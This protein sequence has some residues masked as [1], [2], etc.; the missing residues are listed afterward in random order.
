[1]KRNIIIFDLFG[2]VIDELEHDWKLGL[3]YLMDSVLLPSDENA[4]IEIAKEFQN[5]NMKNR[6]TTFIE[7]KMLDQLALFKDRIGFKENICKLEVEFEFLMASREC[8]LKNNVVAVLEYLKSKDNELYIMSNTIYSKQTITRLLGVFSIEKYFDGV[9]TSSNFG[10]RKPSKRFFDFVLSSIQKDDTIKPN[11]IIFIGNNFEKD[12]L[13]GVSVNLRTVWLSEDSIGYE[14][15]IASYKR[16]NNMIEFMEYLQSDFVYLNSIQENYSMSDGPGN[17]LVI[18]LQGCNIH[19]NG[20][21]NEVT[22]DITYGTR[23]HIKSLAIEIM[24]R[25]NK[26]TRNVTISGGEPLLQEEALVNLLAILENAQLNICMYTGKDFSD[27]SNEVKGKLNYIKSGPYMIDNKD[28][29]KGFY[30]SSNQEFWVK[31]DG[32]IWIKKELR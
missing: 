2:T 24:K 25:L 4:I 12:I 13:G 9:F 7:P 29:T 1:M 27:I 31:G 23:V 32:D 8:K 10:Y 17:R 15:E 3:K 30:G 14:E 28:T 21:H 5:E 6:S 16:V 20:C 11:N 22:W 18:F 19:C 26:Y